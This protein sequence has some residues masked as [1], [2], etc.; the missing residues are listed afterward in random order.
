MPPDYGVTPPA[1]R[2][3]DR[4]RLA[5]VRLQVSD[6]ARSV[7]YYERVLGLRQL[8]MPDDDVGLGA[9]GDNESLVWLHERPEARPVPPGIPV[10]G[11][12]P[13]VSRRSRTFRRSVVM[14]N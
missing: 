7:K 5:A 3:P 2:L 14:Y 10:Q 12:E 9:E 6:L 13:A 8:S 4:T 11:C 1:Y